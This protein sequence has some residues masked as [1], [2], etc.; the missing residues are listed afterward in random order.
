MDATTINILSYNSRGTN[1]NSKNTIDEL[2]DSHGSEN[3]VLCV[4]EHFLMHKNIRKLSN[5]FTNITVIAKGAMKSSARVE[6][7]RAKGALAI[8]LPKWMRSKTSLVECENWRLQAIIINMGSKKH[9]LVNVYLP[10]DSQV[11]GDSCEKL[12]KTLGDVDC[13]IQ[14]NQFDNLTLAG[15][16]NADTAR[17]SSHVEV[18]RNFWLE[19]SLVSVCEEV[20]YTR[21]DK[22]LDHIVVLEHQKHLVIHVEAL[23]SVENA[24]D[25]E[26]IIAKIIT[27]GR[28][29]E[30]EAEDVEE[31]FNKKGRNLHGTKQI[32]EKRMSTEQDLMSS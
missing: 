2:L 18:V 27:P 15:D 7:G 12:L 19:N 10:V 5:Q 6:I 25:H 21:G 14:S 3:S 29:S 22:V 26:P 4:Q 23:Q 17:T 20:D 31:T 8:L 24:S 1:D 13:I 28:D 9:L 16:W 32:E 30:E 11:I